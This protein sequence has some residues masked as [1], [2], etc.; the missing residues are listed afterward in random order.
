MTLNWK[1]LISL[2]PVQSALVAPA[3]ET[4]FNPKEFYFMA[5]LA[6][7]LAISRFAFSAIDIGYKV[8]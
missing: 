3:R 5:F 8:L 4:D 6:G 7:A 2:K 1:S